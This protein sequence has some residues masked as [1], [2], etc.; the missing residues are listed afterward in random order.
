MIFIDSNEPDTIKYGLPVDLEMDAKIQPLDCGDIMLVE[1]GKVMMIE[2]KT[3]GDLLNSITNGRF[4][5]Q[6]S[7]MV[8][9]CKFPLVL[10]HGDLKCNKNGKVVADGRST[11]FSW[12]SLHMALLSL[13]AGGVMY[14][15][16]RKGDLADAIK[17]L[18]GWLRKESHLVVQKR[19]AIP[20]LKQD[21]KGLKILAS[22]PG[23]KWKKAQ[24]LM[25][26]YG[27]PAYAIAE[28]TCMEH[29]ECTLPPGFAR[30]TVRNTR[31]AL[32]LEDKERL[33]MCHDIEGEEDAKTNH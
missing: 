3:A 7:R 6:A 1:D 12:W 11:R 29:E 4:V 19:E 25:D 18:Q 24:A 17:Y 8:E 32:R 15:Q 20:F 33:V 10:C 27:K 30:G 21:D 16:V 23:I 26:F 5:D 2:R 22:L 28:L 31:E 14:L 13:Q 9:V